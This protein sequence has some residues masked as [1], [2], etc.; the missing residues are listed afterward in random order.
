M[1][2][3]YATNIRFA[4][5]LP[6][7]R[8]QSGNAFLECSVW[9]VSVWSATRKLK[10]VG[11]TSPFHQLPFYSFC[12]PTPVSIASFSRWLECGRFPELGGVR[13]LLLLTVAAAR[14]R[15]YSPAV[16]PIPT[17]ILA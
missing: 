4:G 8:S 6:T 7:S 13:S 15:C 11:V 16:V 14:L 9:L 12:L 3:R 10:S 2:H 17:W 1:I 5:A